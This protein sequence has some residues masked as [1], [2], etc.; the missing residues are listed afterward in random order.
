MNLRSYCILAAVLV[1]QG[2]SRKEDSFAYWAEE[3]AVSTQDNALRAQITLNLRQDCSYRVR[4]WQRSD[5]SG[6]AA[7][8]SLQEGR[9]GSN[10]TTLKFLYPQTDYSFEILVEGS[11][12]RSRQVEFR[13]GSLPEDIPIY[14]VER[15]SPADRAL[16][17]CIMQLDSSSPGYVTFCDYDGN[18][19]W[20][21]SFGEGVRTGWFD[22][23]TQ[24]LAVMTG[25]KDGEDSEDFLRLVNDFRVAD[26]DGN[27]LFHRKANEGFIE[28][29][30]HEFKF[31]PDGRMIAVANSVREFDLRSRGA[32][33][34]STPVWGDGFVVFDADGQ[35]MQSWDC[36]GE[37]SPAEVDYIDPVKYSHDYVHANSV[38]ADSEGN[39]YMTFN[40]IS[41]L[42]K[43]DG[44]TGEVLYRLGAHGDI[45]LEGG[46]YPTGGLHAATVLEPDLVLC[47]DN[48]SNRGYSRA[49]IYR[50]D[51]VAKTARYELMI[52]LDEAY[53]SKN[54]S[55]SQKISDD[56]YLHNGT[57]SGKL[58]FTDA[59]GNVLRVLNR[60]GISYRA[61]YFDRPGQ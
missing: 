45:G 37:L 16:P 12:A 52:N 48:G 50:I 40:R 51:P 17:G 56:L 54:R 7:T 47:Y 14:T 33:A 11:A 25:F 29:A 35:I 46:D 26:L 13:T 22:P 27:I 61:Y 36:F 31:L 41:E 28:N 39:F 6:T 44:T 24:R 15:T 20:Y 1:L 30:H 18:I 8:T 2:C 59:S 9:A 19:V 34:E 42:W 55:N 57:V 3:V 49:V 4:Y 43:I 60:T 53:S 10:V 58:V 23:Q 38:D 21:Q 5:E 32:A